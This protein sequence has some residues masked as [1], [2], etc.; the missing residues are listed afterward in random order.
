MAGRQDPTPVPGPAA[1]AR[2]NSDAHLSQAAIVLSLGA[3]AAGDAARVDRPT[4]IGLPAD[5]TPLGRAEP[6]PLAE[7][8]APVGIT[9]EEQRERRGPSVTASTRAALME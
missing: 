4:D 6:I 8:V 9:A 3:A 5:L 2:R 1:Y 7:A